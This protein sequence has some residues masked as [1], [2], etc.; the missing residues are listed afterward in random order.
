MHL[1]TEKNDHSESVNQFR[2]TPVS[3][4]LLLGLVV[5]WPLLSFLFL[6]SQ[7]DL[8]S[9]I[10]EPVSEIYLPTMVIQMVI[11]LAVL[12]AVLSERM[13][14]ADIGLKNFN[15]WTIPLATAFLFGANIILQILQFVILSGA[16]DSITAA[17]ALLPR[18]GFEKLLWLLLCAIV[19][20][21]EEIA[22]RGYLLTRISRLSGGQWWLAVL[23]SSFAFASGHLYQGFGGFALIFVYGLMFSALYLRTGSLFPGIIAHFLQDSLV[24]L[25]PQF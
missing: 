15:R 2:F 23:L 13:P 21:A 17:A 9:R 8:T 18:T 12:L 20:F 1:Q 3:Y 19:A 5:A 25:L 7:L 24:L 16:P 4:L 14:L 10:E 11:L 6:Q 22:Y